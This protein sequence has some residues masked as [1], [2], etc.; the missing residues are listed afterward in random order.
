LYVFF[1]HPFFFFKFL[2]FC[3]ALL[4]RSSDVP[5]PLPQSD[6]KRRHLEGFFKTLHKYPKFFLN[7][8]AEIEHRLLGKK[9]A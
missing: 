1:V 2:L 9:V 3:F 5:A 7:E 4:L 6:L 8:Q